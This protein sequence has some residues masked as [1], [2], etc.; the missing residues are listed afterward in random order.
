MCIF[1]ITLIN[2]GI[3][4]QHNFFA[5]PGSGPVLLGMPDCEQLKLLT[6]NYQMTSDQHKE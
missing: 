1:P 3:G 6:V 5:V 4:Y 2:K